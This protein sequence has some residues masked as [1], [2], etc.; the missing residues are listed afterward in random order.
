M[1]EEKLPDNLRT[2]HLQEEDLRSKALELI[3]EDQGLPLHLDMIE[4]AMDLCDLYR[5]VATNDEDEKAVQLLSMRVFNALGASLKLALSGYSQNSALIMRDILETV[6]LVGMFQRDRTAIKRWREA[7]SNREKDEFRPVNVRKFLDDHDG[8]TTRRRE[9]IYKMFSELAGHP[10]M[11][12]MHMMRPVKG[13]DS[14][15]GPFMEFSV[16][17][18]VLSEMGRLAVQVGEIVESFIPADFDQ[19][20]AS[21]AAFAEHKAQWIKVFYT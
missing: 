17:Q 2:L 4:S 6:F 20:T 11:N 15:I 19:A 10:S 9:K 7:A 16:L 1:F 18:A 21:R 14:V 13:G 8:F 12:S 5:Q 3:A